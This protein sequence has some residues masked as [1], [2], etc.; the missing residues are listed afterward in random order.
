M[1][2]RNFT[3]VDFEVEAIIKSGRRTVRGRSENLS[4]RGLF[5][6]TT[7]MFDPGR[8]VQVTLLL[9]GQE[10]LSVKLAGKVVRREEGGIAVQFSRM[11]LSVFMQLKRIVSLLV[12]DEDHVISEFAHSIQPFEGGEGA[13][14]A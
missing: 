6:R 5:F 9:Q 14:R 13:G 3:R 7:E 12:G 11:S 10:D 4:L 8:N 2:R 1:E